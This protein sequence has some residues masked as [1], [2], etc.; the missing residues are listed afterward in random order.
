MTLSDVI[1]DRCFGID[2][3]AA[4]RR[5]LGEQGSVYIERSGLCCS[6]HDEAAVAGFPLE[7]GARADTQTSAHLRWY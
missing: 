7:D 4:L 6:T 2:G 1:G 5:R 3:F